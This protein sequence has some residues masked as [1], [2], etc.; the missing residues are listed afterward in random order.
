MS[1]FIVCSSSSAPETT[2]I[3]VMYLVYIFLCFMSNRKI[4]SDSRL[5]IYLLWA[6]WTFSVCFIGPYQNRKHVQELT[7]TLE[8]CGYVSHSSTKKFPNHLHWFSAITMQSFMNHS[9]DANTETA[10]YFLIS[11]TLNSRLK[12]GFLIQIWTVISALGCSHLNR[13]RILLWEKT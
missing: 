4:V 12:I 6:F 1:F 8:S 9:S 11:L 13:Y 5:V 10:F 7:Y 3:I 2:G